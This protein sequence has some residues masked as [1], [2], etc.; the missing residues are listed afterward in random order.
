MI[1]TSSIIAS[2]QIR[3]KKSAS[4]DGVDEASSSSAAATAVAVCRLSSNVLVI[5]SNTS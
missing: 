3:S 1:M 2:V 4:R 5:L